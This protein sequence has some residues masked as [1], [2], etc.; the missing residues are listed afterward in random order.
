MILIRELSYSAGTSARRGLMGFSIICIML[1]HSTLS[2]SGE[3]GRHINEIL[4]Q[5]FQFGVDIFF[6]LSGLGLFCAFTKNENLKVFYKKR[7]FRLVP[8]Y[9]V[10]TAAGLI[11]RLI[12]YPDKLEK[13]IH[14]HNLLNFYT[15]NVLTVWFIAAIATLYLV[16]PLLYLLQKHSPKL[17]GVLFAASLIIPFS[18]SM[19]EHW[20][21]FS[22]TWANGIFFVRIPVFLAGMMYAKSLHSGRTHR[23]NLG[24]TLLILILS[25]T[26]FL[27]NLKYNNA[28][29]WVVSRL[30]FGVIAVC[31]VF[32]LGT[33]FMKHNAS[34]PVRILNRLGA[35]T[36]N[37][38]LVN[39]PILR[40]CEDMLTPLLGDGFLSS[41]VIN[42]TAAAVSIAAAFLMQYCFEKLKLPSPSWQPCP[43]LKDKNCAGL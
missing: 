30:L 8:A 43:K 4:Q 24:A 15:D 17:F 26:A 14:E 9:L 29:V 33:L 27:F 40:R 10:V 38:Y 32:L 36:L 39:E 3:T 34:L 13:F 28:N 37:I 2:F 25:C 42:L 21:L 19:M 31:M 20:D 5:F 12:A 1:C 35:V 18:L 6:F 41:L 7:F 22:V 23:I 16:F 11:I